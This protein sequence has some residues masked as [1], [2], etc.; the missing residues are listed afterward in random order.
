VQ[1]ARLNST[2]FFQP[3]SLVEFVAT[4]TGDAW[5]Y[6]GLGVDL[7]SAP[8]ALFGTVSGNA[9]Y[10]RAVG[11]NDILIPG[12]WFS[13]PHLFRLEWTP[14]SIRYLIDGQLVATHDVAV[15]TPMRPIVSDY[16]SGG[17]SITVDDI[18]VTP[19]VSAG[20]FTSRV[21]DAGLTVAW[22][23]ATWSA[24]IP[25]GTALGV[26][27]RTGQTAVPDDS[28]TAFI[29]L[30]SSGSVIGATA[31]YMQYRIGM[32]TALADQSPTL[33]SFSVRYTTDPDTSAPAIIARSPSA[34]QANVD[35]LSAVQV[36][37]SELL[38]GASVGPTAV[39]LRATGSTTDVAANL[40][41]SGG[42]ITLQPTAALAGNTAYDVIVAGS[43]GDLGGNTLGSNVQWSFT[44]GSGQWLQSSSQDFALGSHASTVVTASGDGALQL[45]PQLAD[46]FSGTSLGGNWIVQSWAGHGGGPAETVVAGGTLTLAGE[47]ITSAVVPEGAGLAGRV[48]FGAAPYQHFGLATDYASFAGNYW[49]KFSTGG[50]SNTLFARVNAS[51]DIQDVNLGP[52]PAGF[53]DYRIVPVAGGF[54]FY[55]DGVLRTTISASFPAETPLRIAM[56]SFLGSSAGVLTV[57]SVQ[58]ERYAAS[59]EFVS[60]VFDATRSANWGIASWN[61]AVPAGTTII[62]ETRSGNSANPDATWSD[63]AAV[64]SGSQVASPAGQYLQYRVRM[65]TATFD[66][67]PVLTDI[68]FLWA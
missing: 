32:S 65:T 50:T 61:A 8:W 19:F 45:A 67:T 16:D 47:Q 35:P 11:M 59:G 27:V 33:E 66:V 2:A 21:F 51:N 41:L 42:T 62:V 20:T 39:R 28:W 17:G 63:W 40:W 26:S 43:I 29:P 4:L 53:H 55:I 68:L 36:V 7:N 64:T 37:F 22:D 31:R 58:L 44:T 54:Q 18:R 12:S 25:A 49:A 10:A 30:G 46:D 6:V 34:G 3:G 60:S 5:Q 52:L 23:A 56:S 24:A 38:D 48:Q 14:G 9:L 57:D 1:G 13:G 15:A